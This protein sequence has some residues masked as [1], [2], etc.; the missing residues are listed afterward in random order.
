[1]ITLLFFFFFLMIRRPPRSTLF[2]YTTLFRSR[3]GPHGGKYTQGGLDSGRTGKRGADRRRRHCRGPSARADALLR[4]L[5]GCR[6]I[7]GGFCGPGGLAAG[8]RFAR[9][10]DGTHC[11]RAP[12]AANASH[13]PGAGGASLRCSITCSLKCCAVTSAR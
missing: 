10:E 12:G 7:P 11:G 1:M 3:G 2:P 9:R 8:Q 5:G 4:F 6:E 13:H